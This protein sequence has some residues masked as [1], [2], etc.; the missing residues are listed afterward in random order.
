MFKF[1]E[2]LIQTYQGANKMLDFY[3]TPYHSYGM[4]K[5]RQMQ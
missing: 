3:S 1:V 2:V 5:I 4:A